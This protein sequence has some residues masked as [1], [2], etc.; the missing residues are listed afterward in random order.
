MSRITHANIVQHQG[1]TLANADVVA[2]GIS[3]FGRLN[4]ATINGINCE[5]G[6]YFAL[7]MDEPPVPFTMIKQLLPGWI[8]YFSLSDTEPAPMPPGIVSQA[9]G[10]NIGIGTFHSSS[11]PHYDA[12][13]PVW[14]IC[15]A[16]IQQQNGHAHF[17]QN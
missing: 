10:Q 3:L 8:Y 9:P 6:D 5:R 17:V 14:L 2:K 12:D 13:T 15:Q 11:F 1:Q 4:D 16:T 7:R